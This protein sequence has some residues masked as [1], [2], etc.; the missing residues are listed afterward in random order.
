MNREFNQEVVASILEKGINLSIGES[1]SKGWEVCKS[2]MGALIGFS[3][4]FLLIA[5]VGMV[6]AIIPI[7]GMIVYYVGLIGFI[8]G[9]YVFI[10]KHDNG[11]QFSDFFKGFSF[12][13]QAILAILVMALFQ[14]PIS[15]IYGLMIDFNDITSGNPQQILQNMIQNLQNNQSTLILLSILAQVY[16]VFIYMIYIFVNFLIVDKKANFWQA[17]EGS[18]KVVMNKIGFFIAMIFLLGL[19]N[20]VGALLILGIFVTLPLTFCTLYVI[21]KEVFGTEVGTAF[22]SRVDS[23]GQV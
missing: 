4:L 7:A 21:Y 1:L 12:L 18:R 19:L 22:D 17:M 23:F 6:V 10:T 16:S 20:L 9:Y 3:F 11:A 15:F 8:L 13:G 2:R 14:L 5:M